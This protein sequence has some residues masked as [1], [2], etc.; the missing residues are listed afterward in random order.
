MEADATVALRLDEAG[1][2]YLLPATISRS[3]AKVLWCTAPYPHLSS[4]HDRLSHTLGY[5]VL[6]VFLLV[7]MISIGSGFILSLRRLGFWPGS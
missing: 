1:Q 6:R 5:S 2:S 3:P 7:V 4:S